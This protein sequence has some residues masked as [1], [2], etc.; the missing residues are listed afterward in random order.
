MAGFETIV[1]PM[2]LPNIRPAP[3]QAVTHDDP[4]KGKVVIAGQGTSTITGSFNYSAS[5]Q[6][7][8]ATESK[9]QFD[10][11][12]ISPKAGGAGA[13]QARASSD[14][15]SNVPYIDVEVITKLWF[16]GSDGK[17]FTRNYVPIEEDENVKILRRDVT[18]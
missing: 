4:E 2:I 6:K 16:E 3:A 9:R 8:S 10:E 17:K 5:I 1:R 15:S 18:R 13:R 12:R 11:V 14:S 7:S